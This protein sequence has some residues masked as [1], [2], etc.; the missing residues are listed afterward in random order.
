MSND[1]D[2]QQ[3]YVETMIIKMNKKLNNDENDIEEK[4]KILLVL[5]LLNMENCK[6]INEK[7][8]LKENQQKPKHKNFMAI[9][10]NKNKKKKNNKKCII[11]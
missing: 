5:Q 9:G 1:L 3:R 7:K 8:A 10:R 4:G 6:I 11:I 2:E